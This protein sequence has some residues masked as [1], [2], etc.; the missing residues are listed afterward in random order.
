MTALLSR[1]RAEALGI[2]ER[3]TDPSR[4]RYAI[5]LFMVGQSA[6]SDRLAASLYY[7]LAAP[8]WSSYGDTESHVAPLVDGLISCRTARRA[9]DIG[10][11]AGPSAAAVAD[12]D[13]AT[14]VTAVDTSRRMLRQARSRYPRPNLSFKHATSIRLPFP[15]ASFD[16]VTSLNAIPVLD[17]LRRVCAD[18][19]EVLM[20]STVYPVRDE[21]SAWVGRWHEAGFSRI[22][23]GSVGPGSWEVFTPR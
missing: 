20:A 2:L 3:V 13:A 9:L 7:F 17:E 8:R 21:L 5:S 22:R 12:R 4:Q 6:L 15:A 14:E 23:T 10:T 11:G 1:G 16:L 18:D 19:A